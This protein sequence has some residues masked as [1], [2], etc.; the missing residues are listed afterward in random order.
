MKHSINTMKRFYSFIFLLAVFL[1]G[2]KSTALANGYIGG[3]YTYNKCTGQ[4]HIAIRK[5]YEGCG[6]CDD[7][8]LVAGNLQ[9]K[10]TSN[11][12]VS[13][14]TWSSSC[15]ANS[16]SGSGTAS[17]VSYFSGSVSTADNNWLD[18][19]LNTYPSDLKY[20]IELRNVYTWR[21]HYDQSDHDDNGTE[22]APLIYLQT[23]EKPTSLTASTDSCGQVT[24]NWDNAYQTWETAAG[25]CT[26][27]TYYNYIYRD[28][29]YIGYTAGSATTYKDYSVSGNTNFSYKVSQN[30][31]I[32]SG[33]IISSALSSPATGSTKATP[34]QP[35][36]F[37]ASKNIC[38][39]TIDLTWE[40]NSVNPK[41][42]V[43]RR[44]LS[45]NGT[46]TLIKTVDVNERE[47]VD[48]SRV[49]GTTYY[50]KIAARNEC[51]GESGSS[52]AD[53]ISP[54]DPA[55][56]ANLSSTIDSVNNTITINWTDNANN[57]T[58]YVIERQDDE[59]NLVSF[60]ANMNATSFV[61]DNVS[62]CRLYKYSVR[63]FSDCTPS[64]LKST[65]S[66][67]GILPPPNLNATF[68]TNTKK[69]TCSKGYFN[70]RV[71]LTWT[72]N[73]NSILNNFKIYR[74]VLGSTL[75]SVQ[76]TSVAAGNGSY[77][78]NNADAGVFYKYTLFAYAN[79][80]GALLSSNKTEDVGFRNPTAVIN[81]HVQY[82][83]GVAVK[84][85]KVALE[86]STGSSGFAL[87][88]DGVRVLS[89]PNTPKLSTPSAVTVESWAR[90]DSLG[91]ARMHLFEKWDSYYMYYDE[92][93]KTI[94]FAVFTD[95][96]VYRVAS[97][98]VFGSGGN[99]PIT[100]NQY[101]HICGS[102]DST[103]VKLFL[104][105]VRVAFTPVSN[106]TIRTNT[107][108]LVIGGSGGYRMKGY[109]DEVRVWN[110]SRKDADVKRDYERVLNGDEPG[111]IVLYHADENNGNWAYDVSKTG[112]VF[113]AHHAHFTGT[114]GNVWSSIVPTTTQ[115]GYF[116][117]TN[118]CGDYNI[119][120]I[121]YSGT[122]E[123]FK[124]TPALGVHS[125]SP[126]NKILFI[127][128]G[129]AT[130]NGI[131][132]TDQSSFR[133]RGDV[134]YD[135][136]TGCPVPD[137]YLLVDG[138]NV[139]KNNLP[140]KTDATGKFDIQV[141]IGE[142]SITVSMPNHTFSVGKYP[143]TPG[144]HDFLDSISGMHFIDNTRRIVY[145]RI[146]GGT[147]EW[148]KPL[149][150]GR[151]KNNI[152]KAKVVFNATNLCYSATATTVDSSGEFL[153]SLLPL[154]YSVPDFR[155]D[156]NTAILFNN[157]SDL[158]LSQPMS[159]IT[160]YDTVWNGPSIS[161]VDSMHYHKMLQSPKLPYR[162]TPKI[163]VNDGNNHPFIGDASYTFQNK[164]DSVV[165]DLTNSSPFGAP[166][167][168]QSK[169]YQFRVGA[170]EVYQNKDGAGTSIKYDSV[171]VKQGELTINNDLGRYQEKVLTINL[172]SK[173]TLIKFKGGV[174]N[175]TASTD[176]LVPSFAN[177]LGIKYN[178]GPVHD[179]EWKPNGK[180]FYGIILGSFS[181]DG[182]GF[183]SYGP[184]VV[185]HI[186]R[187]P[188]G[189]ESFSTLETGTT[190]T[191]FASYEL[192]SETEVG[193]SATISAGASFSTGIGVEIE[194][195]ISVDASVGVTTTTN[196]SEGN[197]VETVTT[198]TEAV[199][200]SPSTD[201]VGSS[202]DI[203]IGRAVNNLFGTSFSVKI[204][205]DSV[206]GGAVPCTTPY[207]ASNGKKYV[208]S[209]QK[210]LMLVPGGFGTTFYYTQD[211]IINVL[212]P[213]LTHLRNNLFN[214]NGRF[215]SKLLPDDPYYGLNNDSPLIFPTTARSSTDQFKTD[216]ADSNGVSY[217]WVKMPSDTILI[218]S[219]RFFNQQI[220]LW[221]EAIAQNEME[222]YKAAVSENKSF[223]A[224][225]SVTYTKSIE[226]TKTT[227]VTYE[228][229]FS[230]NVGLELSAEINGIGLG[231]DMGLTITE[232]KGNSKSHSS[233]T[234][235]TWSYT[236]SDPDIG[237]NYTVDIKAAKEGNGPIFYTKG[238]ASSCPYE[239]A[240]KSLY[241]KNSSGMAVN[242]TDGTQRRELG[243]LKVNGGRTASKSNI[244]QGQNA[245]F[246]LQIINDSP[247]SDDNE[248]GL[249]LIS[250]SNP[251]GAIVTI[252]GESVSTN[253]FPVS[254]GTPLFKELVIAKG[255]TEI[256]YDNL[257]IVIHSI[258]STDEVWD[259]VFVSAHFLP[260][261][262][263]VAIASPLDLWVTNNSFDQKMNI[264]MDSYDVNYT[265][266]QWMDFEYKPSSEATW[267]HPQYWYNTT[268]TLGGDS[269][270]LSQTDVN[271]SY[272]WVLG[273]NGIPD[274]N[275]DLRVVSHCALADYESPVYSGI[276]DRKNPE[277]FGTPS[278]AD[279]ILDP[280]DDISIQFN[281]TINSGTTTD[282]NF[283]IKAVLNGTSIAHGTSLYFDGVN[284]AAEVTGGASLQNRDFT[285][286]FW[287]KRKT[288]GEQA[289]I[290]QGIDAL[291]SMFIGFNSSDNLVLKL[292][293][294]EVASL[295]SVTDTT[296]WAH[297]AVTYNYATHTAYLYINS[298]LVSANSPGNM[299]FDYA[300]S[301][302]LVIAKENNSNSKFFNGN[303]HELRIWNKT[304]SFGDVT[305]EMN[306]VLN[307]NSNGLL[308][309]WRMD[310]AEGAVATDAIRSRNATISGAQWQINPNGSATQLD[311]VDDVIKIS[312]LSAGGISKEMDFTLE[313]WFNSAQT[314]AA[315]LFS[316]GKG[317]GIGT[318]S[319]G[320]T[321]NIQKDA[322]G[323]IHVFHKG[324]DFIAVDTNSFDGKWHHFAMVMQRSGNLCA[325]LDGKLKNSMVASAFNEVGFKAMYLGARGYDVGSA[326]AYDNHFQGKIDEFR[327]WSL[328]RKT[329]Q[330]NRDKLNRLQGNESG[331]LVY[332]PFE[333]YQ[334]D[335]TGI[336]HLA[337]SDSNYSSLGTTRIPVALQNGATLVSQTP[338]IKLPRP[339]SSIPYS[340]SINNDK[341]VL[342]PNVSAA[343]IENVTLDITTKGIKDLHG[344]YMQSP[345]TW[346][347]Y[348]NKNQVKWQDDVL[349]FTINEGEGLTFT[350]DMVN[351]GGALKQYT[352]SN[353]PSWMSVGGTNGSISPNSLQ[354]KTFNVSSGINIG[355]YE[356][357]VLLTTDFGYPEKLTIRL[358]VKAIEPD[359]SFNPAQYQHSMDIIGQLKIDG[360]ISSN[361]GDQLIAYI[362][363]EIRGVGSL[364][365]QAAY[366]RYELFLTAYNNNLSGDSVHFSI[367]NSTNGETYVNVTPSLIFEE[368]SLTGTPSAPQ[369]FATHSLIKQNIP[370]KQGWTWVSFPIKSSQLNSSNGLFQ[371][372]NPTVGDVSM[373]QSNF[374]Q[375]ASNG[376]IGSLTSTGGYAMANSYKVKVSAIDTIVLSGS[377]TLPDSVPVSVTPGW[378]WIG[379]TSLKNIP[380]NEALGNYSAVNGDLLKGQFSFAYY[381]TQMGW[382]GSLA[383]M[384]PGEGY[385]LKAANA[386]TFTYP[387]T[388]VFGRH[389][390]AG[391]S[392]GNKSVSDA[393][394]P[395]LFDKNMSIIAHSNICD[396]VLQQQP[397]VLNVYSGNELRGIAQ[398]VWVESQNRYLFFVTAYSNIENES[399]RF[400]FTNTST[401]DEYA[402]AQ[403]VPFNENQLV[404]T[405]ATPLTIDVNASE[406]CLQTNQATAVSNS[407]SNIIKDEL[408]EIYPNPFNNELHIKFGKN[409]TNVSI[410][411]VD[412]VGKVVYAKELN[413]AAY[414]E[415]SLNSDNPKL[416]N[417]IYFVKI[418]SEQ[419]TRT[420]KIVKY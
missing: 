247:T 359:F 27:L 389:F 181:A 234:S 106:K 122:G 307:R 262:T 259:T 130:Q 265:G 328:S 221:K 278:P 368:G 155:V 177:K 363:G 340:F 312:S 168:T 24:L 233:T 11:S 105:G 413:Q 7:D 272:Q 228:S 313:F 251:N 63:V 119:S 384:I 281:E 121:R 238:G 376:W 34:N 136:G 408:L 171:A 44:G 277:P 322:Q 288:L 33:N 147:D 392:G 294:K 3:T 282:A 170:I 213:S 70:N 300:G 333:S 101:N 220:R 356:E 68:D 4:I 370:L 388:A 206:C 324:I 210:S 399:L 227:S 137:V 48:S 209:S 204:D 47:Y 311:G 88:F 57:E 138:V 18:V 116:G 341:V 339:V 110:I 22:T 189:S 268:R 90:F 159:L 416:A 124:V 20:P 305:S 329:E 198:I 351:T 62:T 402:S 274:G 193:V 391:V 172:N 252:D 120:G 253:S 180:Y 40:W 8:W 330:I 67:N 211:H 349:D 229:V 50:Y 242:L 350:A 174:P 1:V 186:M 250:S 158:D 12:W 153:I 393:F 77:I 129:A 134:K 279:G 102:F 32:G 377:I 352:I 14:Q 196:K 215:R 96:N 39:G 219:V 261:C 9:Y 118:A 195:E 182:K 390:I 287:A 133:V 165:F 231:A 334:T 353:L 149:V 222:K 156:S 79:C 243:H 15:D 38:D 395:E 387:N 84:D 315:T 364:M 6:S 200:T 275:Y 419:N 403:L 295:S 382:L 87:T 246:N 258:C 169:Y 366:D 304:K 151:T 45:L 386:S 286:E 64:G 123:N 205:I 167:F 269:I 117:Y 53:G 74:K 146:V 337:P 332:L 114:T 335:L 192:G 365:Y 283:D 113:N 10:N 372:V 55:L 162:A 41:D 336:V 280:N 188:P 289:V 185:S 135:V 100:P 318:D 254:S 83:G 309:D 298:S 112:N 212:I 375:Y 396:E 73:N 373:G 405:P 99:P 319:L 166:V 264:L 249:Q 36:N 343:S 199:S 301:G 78:D 306:T 218:D 404:G 411:I 104:N 163:W 248:Y 347:A 273:P 303:I 236:L 28:G 71:E 317:D 240:E 107:N 345:K 35:T 256:N 108:D 145:G 197:E 132:F 276:V 232:T 92:S 410:K 291:Q 415:I 371:N 225:A 69:L 308:Y 144:D 383:T 369:T 42:F 86:K 224:G 316:N 154:N 187:D 184:E 302:K 331:L 94:Q 342:T 420:Y 23:I 179:I 296:Q 226:T 398:P 175:T 223:S 241:Y 2:M 270:H 173:D 58:K 19:Y 161:R 59:G 89:T 406:S 128:D 284:D 367:W 148:S 178:D 16:C 201:L 245:V 194:T 60:N 30:F 412:P 255:A 183:V 52:R 355:T 401:N 417:G 216:P 208:A 230:K 125:F 320:L 131:D 293:D 299:L 310:E 139:L 127:G 141:P 109:M 93:S 126:G 76:I 267:R 75:D 407:S 338:T 91:N 344:N 111:L 5:D 418:T 142:H 348:I 327:F 51:D 361:V 103:G 362:N 314:A 190:F 164:T 203:Y 244:P 360:V 157:N 143:S 43:I 13:F 381:D 385:M 260:G 17:S 49:R 66:V 321:W 292:G 82:N 380:V 325:Y 358:K 80:N 31:Y 346:I 54:S 354:T 98:S 21:N 290:S 46:Y 409:N 85:V 97:Y 217:L 140:I 115:M 266:L 29:A 414:T 397:I 237:D 400:V 297:Y 214:P 160:V 150:L 378:N 207:T 285:I 191:D 65:A 374:D 26:G 235:T 72:N 323:K 37:K 357:D 176:P 379:F 95:D 25:G 56:A 202:G 152:G 61:D 394:Q 263:P 81:G 271:T 326:V 239:G 257:A